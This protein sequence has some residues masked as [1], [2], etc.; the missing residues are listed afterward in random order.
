MSRVSDLFG[1]RSIVPTPDI[2][3]RE[4]YAA[5]SAPEEEQYLQVL[6]TNT[7]G[8]T[9][10][11]TQNELLQESTALHQSMVKSDPEFVAKAA[12]YARQKGFMRTQPVLALATL[13]SY[14]G[15]NEEKA[16]RRQLVVETFDQVVRTPNDFY[17][18]YTLCKAQGNSLNSRRFQRMM[19]KWLSTKMS[20]YWAIKYGGARKGQM[21]LRHVVRHAHPQHTP[22]F[23]YIRQ[24][25][26]ETDLSEL[27]QIRA[28]EA[29]KRASTGAEKVAAIT[30]GR[31]PHEVASTFAGQDKDVWNA[32]APQM[33][34]FAL[35]RN[36]ATLER[37]G[38][39]D[40]HRKMI[41]EKFSNPEIIQRSGIFPFQFLKAFDM[42]QSA[43]AKDAI[44]DAVD[45][46]LA[47]VPSMG[48]KVVLSID[49]SGSMIGD[50]MR[51]AALIGV[52]LARTAPEGR[53]FLFD[54]HLEEFQVSRRDSI[55]T[56]A[57]SISARGGTDTSLTLRY[58]M[59]EN[60]RADTFIIVTDE[61]QNAGDYFAQAL[62]DYRRRLN[63]NLKCFIIDVSTYRS[64]MTPWNDPNTYYIY[65][66]SPQVLNTMSMLVDGF[67]SMSDVIRAS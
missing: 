6:L 50:L 54:N 12:V 30:E 46:S 42:V 57:M 35:L 2:V 32:I 66:W 33:P 25:A 38:V 24:G 53:M 47:N 5:Y 51:T 4:G 41:E 17:D 65:G 14:Q 59:Q 3:N 19:E 29:L 8:N 58:M 55:L 15:S 23:Q 36:L 49:R 13:A 27:P 26:E 45:L 22:L 44:R 67:G 48:G 56:Q 64:R 39:L 20:E 10:Y 28:F 34:V 31:L 62:A 40:N 11:A 7:L 21:S 16:V 9:F 61:Q 60:I 18:F 37:Q 52:T 63:K 1:K 43:W